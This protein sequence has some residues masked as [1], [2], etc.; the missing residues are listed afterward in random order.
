MP[1]RAVP[2]RAVPC[3]AVPW[4][5]VAWRGVA[6]RGVPYRRRDASRPASNPASMNQSPLIACRPPLATRR[7][8]CDCTA[9][10]INCRTRR[11]RAARTRR[12]AANTRCRT[13]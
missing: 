1:C 4:R 7:T 13:T 5:G 10:P 2:C 8:A 11:A 6:W 9:S 12:P 3:R